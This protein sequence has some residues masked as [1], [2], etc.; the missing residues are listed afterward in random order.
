[1]MMM[2][3]A[4]QHAP[5]LKAT[6]RQFMSNIILQEKWETQYKCYTAN[7]R[8]DSCD[9]ICIFNDNETPI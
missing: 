2:I 7:T 6:K 9:S 3:I 5:Y 4:S 1:M 8:S